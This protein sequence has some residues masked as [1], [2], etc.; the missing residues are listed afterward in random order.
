VKDLA[1]IIIADTQPISRIGMAKILA[2][3]YHVLEASSNEDL[4]LLMNRKNIDLLILD[5]SFFP[6]LNDD[7]KADIISMAL[8]KTKILLLSGDNNKQRIIKFAELKP[9]GFLTK[10]CEPKEIQEAIQAVLN[11]KSIFCNNILNVILQKKEAENDC[12]PT[13]LSRRENEIAILIAKGLTNKKIS[14]QLKLSFHTVHTHRKNIM[15]K[16]G[17]NSSSE[18]V[19]Y[20]INSG[21]LKKSA[22]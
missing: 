14:E 6:H 5:Y 21:L 3:H 2:N 12:N 17:V 20:A 19:L 4:F 10:D 11:G 18:V 8:Q 13:K 9:N 7:E 15:K 1:C 16:L 22:L